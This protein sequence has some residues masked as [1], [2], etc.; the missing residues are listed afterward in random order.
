[1]APTEVLARQHLNRCKN[2]LPPPGLHLALL[3]GRDTAAVRARTLAALAAGEIDIVIGTHALFQESVGV[4]RS[5]P[6]GG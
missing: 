3:T 2:M 1:M 6:R 4:P 5:R